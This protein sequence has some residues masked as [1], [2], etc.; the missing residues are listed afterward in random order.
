MTLQN[1]LPSSRWTSYQTWTDEMLR[2]RLQTFLSTI[3]KNALLE[4][5]TSILGKAM[6]ISE[7]FSAG[8]FWCCFELVADDGSLLVARLR[9]PSHPNSPGPADDTY[10][11]ACEVA[12]MRFVQAHLPKVPVPKVYAF[13]DCNSPWAQKIGASYMLIEGFYGNTLFDAKPD[14]CELQ[15]TAIIVELATVQFSTIGSISEFSESAGATVGTLSYAE[16]DGLTAPGPFKDAIHYY[17]AVID[18]KIR[19]LRNKNAHRSIQLAHYVYRDIV[20]NSVVFKESHEPP[21]HFNH[22][23]LGA[24]NILVDGNYSIIAVIDWEFAQSAPWQ[25]HT[26]PKLFAPLANVFEESNK[27]I[28]CDP[29]HVDYRSASLQEATRQRFRKG[30]D[31]A[32]RELRTQGRN[33][34]R[35][36][37]TSLGSK[38]ARIRT[39]ASMLQHVDPVYVEQCTVEMIKIAYELNE[40]DAKKHLLSKDEEMIRVTN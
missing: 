37:S 9:L 10:S 29:A 18:G 5:T 8:E 40:E 19:S 1:Q 38:G 2:S 7:P 30:F 33:I 4:H 6:A 36:I 23:D 28:L 21:F 16:M 3:D 35:S 12:T 25:E 39:L 15:W 17:T 14:L 11:M 13:G 31:N 32:E 27:A 20:Q 22:M 34:G 24:H 26:Y